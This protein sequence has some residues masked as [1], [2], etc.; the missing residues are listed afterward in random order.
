MPKHFYAAGHLLDSGLLFRAF[1][2][3]KT[4]K[5][6][7]RQAYKR[8]P[9]S[10]YPDPRDCVEITEREFDRLGSMF[11]N[12]PID[13]YVHHENRIGDAFRI[14]DDTALAARI[15]HGRILV[16]K[17]EM[18]SDEFLAMLG[19]IQASQKKEA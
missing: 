4:A 18:L 5:T 1:G 10:I 7:Y 9:T 2:I 11:A 13:E 6:A 12:S 14:D 8:T 16:H 17:S 15:V 3:G 19:K